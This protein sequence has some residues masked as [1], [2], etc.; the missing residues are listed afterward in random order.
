MVPART[1]VIAIHGVGNPLTGEI[2]TSITQSLAEG[3]RVYNVDVREFNWNSP[4]LYPLKDH[5]LKAQSA[6]DLARGFL[7]AANIGFEND[8]TEYAGFNVKGIVVHNLLSSAIRLFV[9]LTFALVVILP[10]LTSVIAL[11]VYSIPGYAA[12]QLHVIGWI[13]A[14]IVIGDL[15]AVGLLMLMGIGYALIGV[16]ALRRCP[17]ITPLAVTMRRA[18][19]IL[20]RPAVLIALPPFVLPARTA[21]GRCVAFFTYGNLAALLVMYPVIWWVWGSVPLPSYIL[22]TN[23]TV[24]V[25]PYCTPEL[26][27]R[28]HCPRP[29]RPSNRGY[30]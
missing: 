6:E 26:L 13:L 21:T 4:D 20:L 1:I 14:V 11:P 28:S 10:L 22:A 30:P 7:T 16:G 9:A 24:V 29:N 15:V 18:L 12:T 17:A 3:R 8:P 5:K 23:A 19:L 2:E 27:V 25:L